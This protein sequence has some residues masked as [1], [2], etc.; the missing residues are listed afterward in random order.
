MLIQRVNQ[1][2][3]AISLNTYWPTFRN[4]CRFLWQNFKL[5]L[6][7][8]NRYRVLS[9]KILPRAGQKGLGEVETRQPENGW[10]T[11]LV[12]L[13]E[14]VQPRQKVGYVTG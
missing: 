8:V 10:F 7:I 12:P 14:K 1:H 9:R 3:E 11:E 5:K 2:D 13:S 4:V 6:D